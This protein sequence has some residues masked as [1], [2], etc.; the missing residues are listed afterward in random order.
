MSQM[1]PKLVLNSDEGATFVW[2]DYRNT[3]WDI[4]AQRLDAS[5]DQMWERNGIAVCEAPGTQYSPQMVKSSGTSAIIV[6]E[7]YRSDKKYDLFAQ[8]ISGSGKSIWEKDGIPICMTNGGSRNP[9]LADD[10][11]GGAVIV[12]ADYRSGSSDIYAQR[13]NDTENK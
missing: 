5:G 8:K 9:Q 6:W 12:W 10:G 4:Y 13:I 11:K 3:G 7:D 1:D 2:N